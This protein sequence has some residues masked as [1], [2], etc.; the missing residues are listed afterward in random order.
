MPIR[1]STTRAAL[2]VV[3][4]A[5]LLASTGCHWFKRT[6]NDY[7]RS[8]EN[9]PLEVPPDLDKPPLDN[10][11]QIPN[12]G[13]SASSSSMDNGG[14]P[15]AASSIAPSASA[16]SDASFV[17]AD[18]ASST[19]NRLGAALG[20]IDGV[21]ITQRAQ[22]LNSF[23]VQYKGVTFLLRANS[24]GSNTRVSAIGTDGAPLHTVE[25]NELLG[26]LRGRI[27]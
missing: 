10:T 16:G 19:W 13:R 15:P 18:T 7:Q 22:V 5:A 27:G 20:H 26:L 24:D 17:I 3:A 23:E 14:V 12:A 2:T 8:V 25:A 21:T 11:M 6:N 1:P 9:R 4:A